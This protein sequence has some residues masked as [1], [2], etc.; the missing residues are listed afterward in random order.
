MNSTIDQ[1]LARLKERL[2]SKRARAIPD[3][4]PSAGLRLTP[5]SAREGAPRPFPHSEKFI[6]QRHLYLAAIADGLCKIGISK[7]PKRRL[8]GLS[9]TQPHKAKLVKMWHYAG[10]FE[11]PIHEILRPFQHR[12]EW[13]RCEPRFVEWICEM[14]I[15]QK[16]ENA[17]Q[18]AILFAQY[19]ECERTAQ[20]SALRTIDEDLYALGF[21]TDTRKLRTSQAMRRLEDT[22]L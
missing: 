22:A 5:S 19:M 14:M 20:W 7:K 9:S 12:G 3:S 2:Q 17:T 21:E 13:F 4:P 11:R 15:A 6:A 10:P 18:A 1:R 8:S 16:Q